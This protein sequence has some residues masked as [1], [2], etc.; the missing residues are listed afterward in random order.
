MTAR[1]KIATFNVNGVK[2]RLP[3]LVVPTDADIYNR[4]LWR[5][6]AVM[7]PE[8]R[9]AYQRL[10]AQGADRLDAAPAPGRAHLHT[11][12]SQANTVRPELV[13]GRARASTGSA[14]TEPGPPRAARGWAVGLPTFQTAWNEVQRSPT[15][16]K[17]P[18][19]PVLVAPISH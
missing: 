8:K 6:D 10:L 16:G 1:L 5:E 18:A 15:C 7:Q 11:H 12:Q 3:G 19:F 2:G 4:W 17:E 13:E 14:R 9:A